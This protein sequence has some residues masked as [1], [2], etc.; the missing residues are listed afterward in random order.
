ML[1]LW[2]VGFLFIYKII[3]FAHGIAELAKAVPKATRNGVVL[4]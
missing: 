2:V 4:P 1:I 3:G